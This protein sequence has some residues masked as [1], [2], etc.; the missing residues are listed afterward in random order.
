MRV[1]NV[2]WAA[3]LSPFL[4]FGRGE[5]WINPPTPAPAVSTLTNEARYLEWKWRTD[6]TDPSTGCGVGQLRKDIAEL[7]R[8]LGDGVPWRIVKA[9]A[10]A[11]ACDRI[12]VGVSGLDW[13]PAFACWNRYD[14]PFGRLVPERAHFI[15]TNCHPRATARMRQG[16]EVGDWMLW[17]DFDH[18]VPQWDQV[19][20]LG[21]P[22]LR[23]RVLDCRRPTPFYD[24]LTIVA[25]ASLRLVGRLAAQAERTAADGGGP[26]AVRQAEAL[27]QLERGAPRTA[28]EAMQLIYLYFVMSEHL[29]AMQCRSLS[30]I[31]QTLWPYYREDLAAGRTTEAEFREQF[32]HFLWQWGSIDNY[33]A[34]P[35]TLGGTGADGRTACNPLTRIMLEVAD[36]YGQ[37][38]PKFHLKVNFNMPDEVLDLA[39]DMARR[40]RPLSFCDEEQMWA[41]MMSYGV[42]AEDARKCITRGCYEFCPPD[43]ANSTDMADVCYLKPVENMLAE[44]AAGKYDAATYEDFERDYHR[45]FRAVLVE[46]MGV[47]DELESH[48]E[49]VNPSGVGSLG[50]EHSVRT[51]RDAFANGSAKGNN[52]NIETSGFGTTVDALMAIRE[53][54]YERRELTLAGL[55]RL[56][57]KNWEGREDLRL[58]M[59]RS[60][61]K[62]G[63]NDPEA[64]GVA[65]RIAKNAAKTVNCRPN[66]RGGKYLLSG[67]SARAFVVIGAK[68][69]ATPDGRRRGEE[70][71]KNLSAAIGADSEGV[72]A[73]VNSF[74]AISGTDFP[75]DLPL[76]V[77]FL[78]SAVEGKKG[79]EVMK[80]ALKV[81][82][83][84][85]GIMMQFNVLSPETLRDAQAHSERYPNLQ[86]RV[87]G[88]TVRWN[89]M[90]KVEQDRYIARVE[91]LEN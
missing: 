39:L 62:W 90:P 3:G 87:C 63:A 13:F 34:Q 43:A 58:R 2:L 33:W 16:N 28:Y 83:S 54:V 72:T 47:I 42:S 31:D 40:Q 5:P 19:L 85:G 64:K 53:I 35:V 77:A 24:S 60:R 74:E 50:V 78:P 52:T 36:A 88:W 12:A 26:R 45:R 57:A 21:L 67:H 81:Y 41:A 17:K 32:L 51:G 29:D 10:Y 65:R 15:S 44:A 7:Q 59:L 91:A 70:M 14:L 1:V 82:Y 61:R 49:D 76:D 86:V 22:G 73:L 27:R 89:D 79:L 30:V 84:H 9:K 11:L 8:R 18:S 38:S 48:L 37:P 20:A 75:G 68:L 25:D 66:A 56:M 23:Q 46:L 69:G 71:S 6:V 80:A 55:G 4:A